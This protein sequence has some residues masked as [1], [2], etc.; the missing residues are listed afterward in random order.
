MGAAWER[1]SVGGG[2]QGA[3]GAPLPQLG[4]EG[5][6]AGRGWAP[7]STLSPQKAPSRSAAPSSRGRSAGGE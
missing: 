6:A 5:W 1:G 2:E 3:L 7:L 4:G